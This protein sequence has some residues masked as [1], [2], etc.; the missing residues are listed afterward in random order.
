MADYIN[1]SNEISKMEYDEKKKKEIVRELQR[2]LNVIASIYTEM[3]T[4]TQ[5]GI[6]GPQTQDAIVKFCKREDLPQTGEVDKDTWDRIVEVYTD[7]SSDIVKPVALF[8]SKEYII[9]PGEHNIL[10]STVQVM[11]QA[12]GLNYANCPMLE[13]TGRYDDGTVATVKNIQNIVG[14]EPTGNVNL[15]TWN[16]IATIFNELDITK[17]EYPKS[18]INV[19]NPSQDP[20]GIM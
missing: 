2:Y 12:I 20:Q 17:L 8:P 6:Y 16:H 1:N 10:V 18:F 3:P 4:L 11:L 15:N 5:D 14:I 9:S 7:Y 13:I 19:Q